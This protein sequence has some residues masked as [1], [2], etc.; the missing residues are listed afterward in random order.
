[1]VPK[2]IAVAGKGGTG[3][4][5][6]AALLVTQL[7][8]QNRGP[9]LAIDADPDS[10]LG[11]LLGVEPEQS[12]GDLRE[13]VLDAMKK[14]PAGMTKANYV[15][16][17]L[18]Q[19]IEEANGFDLITMGRGEGAGCYCALNNMIRKFSDD[20]TPSYKWVIID[21]EAGLEHLSRRTTRN[22]DALL[23][24]VS[25]NPLS[26]RSAEKIQSITED[27]DARIRRKYIVTNMIPDAKMEAFKK[28][29]APFRIPHLMD[30][31]YDP[32]LEEVIF[33]GEPLGSL[34][35]APIMKTISNIIETVGGED[36]N[37]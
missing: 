3:K 27:M 2:S 23:V 15:E 34:D 30:I 13:E 36:A 31:P 37:S 4:T 17:G 20:L 33:Q 35:G 24:V 21:N 10:N 16:A 22:V 6:I 14:L 5:T 12:I 26:L 8:L 7:V 1:V 29:L 28:R 18:H 25:D 9:I 19:I 11:D 32:S